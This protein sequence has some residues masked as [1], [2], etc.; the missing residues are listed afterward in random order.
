MGV[1]RG[2]GN[3]RFTLPGEG[4]GEGGEVVRGRGG[5]RGREGGGSGGE[6][7]GG[8]GGGRLVLVGRRR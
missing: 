8:G 2:V 6:G 7:G 3:A 5:R 1:E 4:D